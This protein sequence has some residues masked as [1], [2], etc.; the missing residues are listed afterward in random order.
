MKYANCPKPRR[1][2]TLVEL[3]VVIAIIGVLVALLLPAVQAAREAARRTQCTNNLKQVALAMHNHHDTYGHFPA[4]YYYLAA[5]THSRGDWGSLVRLLPFIEQENLYNILTPNNFLGDIPVASATQTP[6]ASFLCPTDPTGT[7]TNGYANGYGKTNYLM[8]HQMAST[9]TSNSGAVTERVVKMSSVTDGTS[10]T[11]MVGER[12]MKTNLAGG[13]WIGRITGKS[14]C[15]TVGRG[16]LPMNTV[17][18]PASDSACKRHTWASQHPGGCN[19]AMADA[20]TRF[21][22]ETISSHQGY[23]TG[24][25]VT[26]NPNNFIYQNLHRRDDGNVLSSF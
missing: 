12:D 17:A 5:P 14:D 20:S 4:Q 22:A 7:T 21:I 11:I 9:Y 24:C 1:G 16:D 23:T 26:P 15:V 3:L 25:S 18:D 13:V 6:I 8:S 19:F 2:F 10:N